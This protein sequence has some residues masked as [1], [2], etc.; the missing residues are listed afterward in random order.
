[1]KSTDLP[2]P[3]TFGEFRL[4]PATRQ[5][6]RGDR[7]VHLS[8]KAFDFLLTLLARRPAVVTKDALRDLLW[9]GTT[10]VD[11]NLN[12][13]AS[14]IRAALDDDALRPRFV[15]TAHRVGYAFC[16]NAIAEATEGRKEATG[17]ATE[18]RGWLLWKD[19]TIPLTEATTMLGRDPRCAVWVDAPGVSRRHASIRLA[20]EGAS[21]RAQIED[22]ASTNGTLVDGRAITQPTDLADGQEIGIGEATLTYRSVA[23]I[24]APTKRIKRPTSGRD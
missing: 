18:A 11:A 10:V 2:G 7:E 8:P 16:G 4:N 14:E 19:R 9:P 5:L 17:R 20:G 23:A 13:L 24:G 6:L 22:L 15:R 12:N 3:L 1:M 21:A